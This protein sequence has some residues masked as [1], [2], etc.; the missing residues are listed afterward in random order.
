METARGMAPHKGVK[1][2][3]RSERTW[4]VETAPVDG[5]DEIVSTEA[6]GQP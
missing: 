6:A 2:K 3:C 1:F 4:V 5:Y